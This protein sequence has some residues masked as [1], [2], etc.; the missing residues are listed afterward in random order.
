MSLSQLCIVKSFSWIFMDPLPPIN[1]EFAMV[2]QEEKQQFVGAETFGGHD[3]PGSIAMA[4]ND[5]KT[6]DPRKFNKKDRLVCTYCK[7]TK[8]TF[9]KCYKLH[10]FLPGYKTCFKG[11]AKHGR[12]ILQQL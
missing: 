3:Q 8:H 12:R 4:V 11:Q 5:Q 6:N 9:D 7:I 1:K 2:Y 10:G